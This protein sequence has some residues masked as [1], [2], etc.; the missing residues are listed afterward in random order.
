MVD[1]EL[2]SLLCCPESHQEVREAAPE[3]IDKLNEL[4]AAGTL[5]N[6]SG[7]PVNEKLDSGLIRSDGKF[8][9]P[10]RKDIPVMLVEEGIPLQCA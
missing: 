5:N 1:P 10:I 3:L 9:Y 2:L 4:V 8:L 6:R 7:Q